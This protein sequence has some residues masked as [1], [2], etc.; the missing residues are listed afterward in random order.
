MEEWKNYFE[1]LLN[2]GVNIMSATTENGE[3]SYR[4][5]RDTVP[6]GDLTKVASLETGIHLGRRINTLVYADDV[7][8]IAEKEQ[9]LVQTIR[10]SMEQAMRTGLKLNMDKIKYFVVS[11]EN[12]NRLLNV[13]DKV[14][15]RE[16][17]FKYLGA[18]L[19]ES[20]EIDQEIN[21]QIQE[22]TRSKFGLGKLLKSQFL[23]RS[24]K[25]NITRQ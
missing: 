10:T 5:N 22:G 9:D 7:V 17:D 6:L 24:F 16:K 12:D 1:N 11:K 25:T 13:E 15:E 20:N 21:A 18:I 19:N 23:W 4:E 14:F 3:E 8:L 2:V